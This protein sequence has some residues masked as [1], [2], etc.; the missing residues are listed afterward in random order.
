MNRKDWLKILEK[1]EDEEMPPEE[2]CLR[3]TKGGS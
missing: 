1:L 2:P 3:L